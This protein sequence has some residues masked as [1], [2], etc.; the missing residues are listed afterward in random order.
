MLLPQINWPSGWKVD[1]MKGIQFSPIMI[2]LLDPSELI[3][4]L[5]INP[6]I[7]FKHNEHVKFDYYVKEN[8]KCSDLMSEFLLRNECQLTMYC[9]M[10]KEKRNASFR[11]NR[12]ATSSLVKNN[13]LLE[14][15]CNEVEDE[16]EE[17]KKLLLKIR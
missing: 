4:D 11:M 16:N 12:T 5:F 6:E 9:N 3:A 15:L 8:C 1:T 17:D 7:M 10:K 2:Y 14:T 13:L